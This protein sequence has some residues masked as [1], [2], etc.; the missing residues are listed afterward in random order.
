MNEYKQEVI[1]TLLNEL[2]PT[3]RQVEVT[4]YGGEFYCCIDIET[5]LEKN[6]SIDFDGLITA[7]TELIFDEVFSQTI[8]GAPASDIREI[9]F[10]MAVHF[11]R[12]LFN[13]DVVS[14]NE[15]SVAKLVE[16]VFGYP[17]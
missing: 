14:G 8:I 3:G 1:E 11:Y 4:V 15:T 12:E 6:D 2:Y 13:I 17:K 9:T 10:A 5:L 16:E 7:E